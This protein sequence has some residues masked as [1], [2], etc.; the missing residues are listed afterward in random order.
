MARLTILQASQQG[1]GSTLTIHRHIKDGSLPIY[2]EG[3]TKLLEVDDLITLFGEPGAPARDEQAAAGPNR[4]DIYEY[5]RM[6]SELD[7]KNKKNMW[8][9][10]DLAEVVRELK[11]KEAKFESERD[12]LLKVLE[13][14]QA[15]LLREAERA[16]GKLKNAD[17]SALTLN[18]I[19]AEGDDTIRP[20]IT[21]TQITQD[22]TAPEQVAAPETPAATDLP[23]LPL[24]ETLPETPPEVSLEE[25]LPTTP[26]AEPSTI[27]PD[28]ILAKYLNDPPIIDP[29]DIDNKFNPDTMTVGEP[30]EPA[31]SAEDDEKIKKITSPAEP[32][33]INPLIPPL[34]GPTDMPRDNRLLGTTTW[35]LL[36]ALVGGGFVFFEFRTQ[37]MTSIAK[38]MKVLN[39]V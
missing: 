1:F 6:K 15:L 16:G 12:R 24:T 27:A 23:P 26:A 22:S 11:E 38:I 7:Q 35:M 10:A 8:L 21:D 2:E 33:P 30:P 25:S 34:E 5:N 39:G 14:A 20:A 28:D 18:Q 3:D 36:F 9:A 13:Q 4:I 17:G 19:A 31:K 29:A 37:V 32:E